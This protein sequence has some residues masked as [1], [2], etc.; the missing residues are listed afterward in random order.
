MDFKDIPQYTRDGNYRINVSWDYLEETLLGYQE[1]DKKSS[2]MASLDLD[3]DFQRGHVWTESQQIAFVEHIL[4]GGVGS[5]E[6]RFNCVG[7][8][9][10]FRGPFV[11]VDGK[12]RLEAVRKFMRGELKAF[13][14]YLNE[15][16][17]RLRSTTAELIFSINNL[18]T[19]KEVLRWYLEINTGG[20][21]H[22]AQEIQKVREL[23]AKE[24][25]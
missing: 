20:V 18:Q 7:W 12:Q 13:G 11:I 6:I 25:A 19:R 1:R 16:T 9:G 17:G 2:K 21:V 22:T 24:E 15:F 8:M 14:Y 5:K 10:D 3:P 23:L 4:S